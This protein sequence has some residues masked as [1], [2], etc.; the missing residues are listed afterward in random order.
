[1]G[2][3][4]NSNSGVCSAPSLKASVLPAKQN[5]SGYGSTLCIIALK[6]LFG[7]GTR[8]SCTVY[9][10]GI[11]VV[12][13]VHIYVYTSNVMYC[14][15]SICKVVKYSTTPVMSACTCWQCQGCDDYL[16]T[17]CVIRNKVHTNTNI[18]EPNDKGA[19]KTR[20]VSASWH[21]S[22]HMIFS[23]LANSEC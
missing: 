16:Q 11:Y 3:K 14:C 2:A 23:F 17:H 18:T 12:C 6:D 1:M 9:C 22:A 20:Q 8:L 7:L 21:K 19:D 5:K 13:I 4:G 10:K 15:K